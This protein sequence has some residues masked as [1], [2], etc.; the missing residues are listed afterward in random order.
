[1]AESAVLLT[2]SAPPAASN[3]ALLRDIR[4]LGVV[5]AGTRIASNDLLQKL[6]ADPERAWA[7]AHCGRPI[8][9]RHL[10]DRLA[11][12]GVRPCVMRLDDGRLTRGYRSAPLIDA[13]ARYL[14]D[15]AP[16][17]DILEGSDA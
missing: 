7:T 9:P 1:M 10:A 5:S 4:D 11:N 3:L 12:F 13:F 8:T 15:L 17:E 2:A 16:S 6:T 14:S